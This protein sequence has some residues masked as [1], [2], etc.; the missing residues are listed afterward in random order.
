MPRVVLCS[1][2]CHENCRYGHSYALTPTQLV[3][4][5][6]NAKKSPCL[7]AL[8]GKECRT[9]GCPLGHVCPCESQTFACAEL[10]N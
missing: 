6:A 7:W 3:E 4:L 9:P 8:K 2:P 10:H 1:P 5:K